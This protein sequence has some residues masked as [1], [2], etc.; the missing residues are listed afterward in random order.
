MRITDELGKIY[1]REDGYEVLEKDVELM[2]GNYEKCGEYTV[3]KTDIDYNFHANNAR[4]IEWIENY[5]DDDTIKKVEVVYK[6][7]LKLNETVEIY[8]LVEDSNIYFKLISNGVL[9]TI[10]KITK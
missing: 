9:K 7:E 5:L 1:G 4:Y 3:R 6:K 2:D 8:K 10:I